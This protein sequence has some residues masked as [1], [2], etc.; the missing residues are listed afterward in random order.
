VSSVLTAQE[1]VIRHRGRVRDENG[2]LTTGSQ[3][4]LMALAVAPGGGSDTGDEGRSGEQI[5]CTVYFPTGTDVVDSD[6]LTVRGKRFRIIVNDWRV[7]S[8]SAGGI[9]A[10][11]VRGQG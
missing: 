8:R 4:T 3:V 5:A 6:E 10:R 7:T 2:Q 1:P 9:E 11:C